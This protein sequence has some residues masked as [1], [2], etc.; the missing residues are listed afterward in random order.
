MNFFFTLISTF[1][2]FWLFYPVII[3]LDVYFLIYTLLNCFSLCQFQ[4]KANLNS[5]NRSFHIYICI[6]MCIWSPHFA[7][8]RHTWIAV[9]WL[10]DTK[11]LNTTI[12]QILVFT[13]YLLSNY[14][15]YKLCC[16]L[17]SHYINNRCQSWSVNLHVTFQSLSVFDLYT[18]VILFMPRKQYM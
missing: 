1:L 18:L 6:Y 4:N 12:V 5:G 15:R 10:N 7:P 13:I 16:W 11:Y 17:T 8:F 14:I 9:T 2:S 3:W